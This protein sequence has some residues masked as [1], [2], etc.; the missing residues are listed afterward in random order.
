MSVKPLRIAFMGTPDF[1]CPIIQAL[2]DSPHELVCLY[3]QPPREKGRKQK[4]EKTPVHLFGEAQNIEV[5][6][7]ANFKSVNDINDF[8]KLNLDIAI[9]AAYGL[10]LPEVILN[11]P[12]HGCINIHPSLLPRWRGP[13]PVQYTLWMGDKQA[14]VSVMGL[15]KSMDTGPII[16]QKAIDVTPDMTFT[17][18]NEQ[19]WEIGRGLLMDALDDIADNDAVKSQ[20]QSTESVTYCKL[21][22][23]QHG[24]INWAQSTAQEIDCQI[25][26]LNPWPGTYSFVGGKRLKILQANPLYTSSNEFA[27]TILENGCIVCANKTILQLLT[28]QPEN[29][30]PMNI[31]DALNGGYLDLD[32]KL[33]S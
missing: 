20:P 27:G 16:A 18:L 23:K 28:V 12:R 17:T 6:H 14:G 19:L 13:T 7:P 1:V 11:A 22:T 31:E 24:A 15:E 2:I 33:L 4:I 29:K 30:K 3:T 9:V 21:M 8:E 26:G 25:R 32:Q 10:L 5:R